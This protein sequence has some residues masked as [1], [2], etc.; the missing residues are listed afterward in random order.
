[1][2][3]PC[4]FTKNNNPPW[5]FS[6]FLNCAEHHILLRNFTSPLDNSSL[7]HDGKKFHLETRS[8]FNQDRLLV[9]FTLNLVIKLL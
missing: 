1:M 8:P 5:G 9:P 3:E 2:P 6:R 7:A 4:N